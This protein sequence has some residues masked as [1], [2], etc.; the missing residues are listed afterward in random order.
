MRAC[1]SDSLFQEF[2]LAVSK[3]FGVFALSIGNG[4]SEPTQVGNAFSAV[5]RYNANL[6]NGTSES[7]FKSC[8]Y[9]VDVHRDSF[10]SSRQY[11]VA[12]R[13]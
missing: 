12:A 13:Q 8:E 2:Q 5:S 4:T 10:K 7:T 11:I 1:P 3:G 6:T 9:K